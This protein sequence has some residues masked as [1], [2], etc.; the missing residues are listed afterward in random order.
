MLAKS[1]EP[2]S[3]QRQRDAELVRRGVVESSL[4]SKPSSNFAFANRLMPVRV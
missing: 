4:D 2:R 3:A 1:R